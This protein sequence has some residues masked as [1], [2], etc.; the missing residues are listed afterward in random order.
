MNLSI[1]MSIFLSIC[2]TTIMSYIAMA[3]PIGP[4]IAPTIVLCALLVYVCCYANAA[5][6]QALIYTTVSA[7]VGGILATAYGFTFPTL[8]FLDNSLFATWLDQSTF[9]ITVC[10]TIALVAGWYGIWIAR[11]IT[12]LFPET[13]ALP[14]P[15]GQLIYKMIA[16]QRHM[17]QSYE[18][19][20]GFVTTFLFCALQDGLCMIRPCIAKTI[21]LFSTVRY[22]VFQMPT[23]PLDLWPM[24]WAIGF[25]TGHVI[26]MPLLIGS[27][28]RIL[29]VQPVHQLY[30][31]GGAQAD[32]VLAFCSGMV[33]AGALS[34][35]MPKNIG[36][37]YR[38]SSTYMRMMDTHYARIHAIDHI[39]YYEG[40]LVLLSVSALLT[41]F[42][43]TFIA[44]GYLL[45]TTALCAYQII[46]I[47]GK[48]GLAQLGRFATFVLV[49]ALFLF[50]LDVVQITI[51]SVF[52]EVATGVAVDILVGRKV[53]TL[54]G[55]H[56]RKATWFQYLGLLISSITIGFVMWLLIHRFQLGSA[57][58]FAQ[59]AQA[60][61]LLVHAK[62][63]DYIVLILGMIYGIIL[64]QCKVNPMLVLGG[65]LMPLNITIG[66]V[67]GGLL[68]SIVSDSE[69]YFPFWSGVFAANSLWM[70]LRS[71]IN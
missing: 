44:Q 26:V 25:V 31:G 22:S 64:K 14:F 33:V 5:L 40:A 66:L 53:V 6:E 16:V 48:I 2:S 4:W 30:F 39:L 51:I 29:L 13:A 54:A 23:L 37:F 60:R 10:S 38:Q 62:Q 8:Y 41:Y 56:M 47:A 55:A 19:A 36:A 28:S 27:L 12:L 21:T 7:S 58:L 32:F 46:M 17:R 63:F 67:L 65:L 43:F 35:F 15:I 18:L 50:N 11:M 20:A 57:E 61:A 42:N 24:L 59:R 52:V 69:R 45:L 70:L 34:A 3:T 1:V 49:P 68:A 9:F 71:L